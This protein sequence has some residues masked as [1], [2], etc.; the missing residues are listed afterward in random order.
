MR[1]LVLLACVAAVAGCTATELDEGI[2]G[3]VAWDVDKAAEMPAPDDPYLAALFEGYLTLARAERAEYDWDDAAEFRARALRA[4]R[5]QRFGPFDPVGRSVPEAALPDL[6]AAFVELSLLV[7][8][9]GAML[10][11]PR[12]IG[13]AQVQ[14]DCWL[15]EAEEAHQEADIAACRTAYEAL[16]LLIRDLA[17]L[18]DN[19][20]V[21]LPEE[22]GGAPG[23]I[24]LKQGGKKI[25]LDRPFAA[26]GV[27]D[28]FGDLPVAEGEI[29]DAFAD[30]LA[31]RPKPPREFIVTFAFGSVEIRDTNFEQV[32]AAAE[33]ARSRAAAEVIVTGFTDAVG[34][35]AANLALSRRRA[36]VVE[37]AIFNELRAEE[38]VTFLRGGRGER[39]LV[40]KTPGAEEANRRV[41]ILVR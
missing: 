5:G 36:A 1:R 20:A 38:T 21:V 34:D 31:A 27:G 7:G 6:Q 10:R 22:E 32:L 3:G 14:F 28:R 23:G 35:T 12:Q 2:L 8:S 19:M 39:D 26:A 33:E 15:Q 29:R 37:K 16:I 41:V 18:P 24:E 30:A 17:K 13:E 40:V 4:A 11:A 9:E 25:L